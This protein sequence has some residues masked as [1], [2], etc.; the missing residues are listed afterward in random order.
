MEFQKEGEMMVELI[1]SE[2]ARLHELEEAC[3]KLLDQCY[4][5]PVDGS[6]MSMF[7]HSY[8][9]IFSERVQ[10]LRELMER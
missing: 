10:P 4:L 1:S 3:R 6:F 5:I 2:A 8:E 7:Q 9:S